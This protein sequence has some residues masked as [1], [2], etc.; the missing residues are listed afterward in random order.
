MSN[1]NINDIL[2]ELKDKFNEFGKSNRDAYHNFMSYADDIEDI[3]YTIA[4]KLNS[5]ADDIEDIN[6]NFFYRPYEYNSERENRYNQKT[7]EENKSSESNKENKTE[8]KNIIK[9]DLE[10]LKSKVNIISE[11]CRQKIKEIEEMSEDF[12]VNN[13]QKRCNDFID[14]F[15]K[16]IGYINNLYKSALY[17]KENRSSLSFMLEEEDDDIDLIENIK[18]DDIRKI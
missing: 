5:I 13:I 17:R 16:L 7:S 6:Y 2:N 14:N 12:D 8:K 3:A 18:I 15:N 11:K 9:I 10:K 4:D 1:N